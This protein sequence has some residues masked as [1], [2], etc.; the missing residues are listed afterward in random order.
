MLWLDV[1]RWQRKSVV[2]PAEKSN[3]DTS[4]V[5]PSLQRVP[6]SVSPTVVLKRK[7]LAIELLLGAHDV[8]WMKPK[9][10]NDPLAVLRSCSVFA[11]VV[12]STQIGSE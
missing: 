1:T 4:S 12:S 10:R 9:S 6:V 2:V 8:G 5:L 3:T 7:V 11:E